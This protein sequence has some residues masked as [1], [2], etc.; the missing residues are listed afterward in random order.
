GRADVRAGDIALRE[1]GSDFTLA[2]PEGEAVVSLSL[3]GRHN[4]ANALAAA[5]LALACGAPLSAIAGGLT[6]ARP[7]EGRL[8][9]H[10]LPGGAC[11]VDDSYNANP[12]S[13]AAAI[14][15]LAMA[16]GG[17]WLVLGDMRELGPDAVALHE[18]AGHR[19]REAGVAR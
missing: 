9:R 5:A 11:L 2:T 17:G 8:V 7:V 13:L 3:P 12:G 4:V 19:A 6:D 14:D 18:A 15:T 16:K 10:R 1:D